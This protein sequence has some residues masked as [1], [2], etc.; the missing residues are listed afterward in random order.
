MLS[1]MT[2]V[3]L[4]PNTSHFSA[5]AEGS[6]TLG[7]LVLA[8]VSLTSTTASAETRIR[9]DIAVS[10]TWDASGSPYII[11]NLVRVLEGATLTVNNATVKFAAPT[12][13]NM[14]GRQLVV[15]G[16]LSCLN[17]VFTSMEDT[18]RGE[19]MGVRL[20]K[21]SQPSSLEG[22]EFRNGGHGEVDYTNAAI[23]VEGG[24]KLSVKNSWIHDNRCSGI[25]SLDGVIQITDSVISRNGIG[26]AANM[27]HL[28]LLGSTVQH[29][30]TGLW[31]NYVD[32]YALD[33][34]AIHSNRIVDNSDWGIN[35]RASRVYA[36]GTDNEIR[37]NGSVAGIVQINSIMTTPGANWTRNYFGETYLCDCPESESGITSHISYTPVCF[38]VNVPP[39]EG[40]VSSN[41]WYKRVNPTTIISCRSDRIQTGN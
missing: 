17:S 41:V 29:N 23:Y 3:A 36:D 19:W 39:P 1:P 4:S 15:L 14:F 32:S 20:K 18:K 38:T 26:V 5:G 7:L 6:F 9:D 25:A 13:P 30:G 40:P 31:F 28:T 33:R 21:G 12:E 22:C 10:T 16:A 11:E 24:V 8:A 27:A 35:F 37:G 2:S 34:S